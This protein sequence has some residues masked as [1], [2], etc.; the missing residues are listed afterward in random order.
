MLDSWMALCFI[1]FL[2]NQMFKPT[3]AQFFRVGINLPNRKYLSVP[4]GPSPS[5]AQTRNIRSFSEVYPEASCCLQ[6]FS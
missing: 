4:F 2:M 6:K 3:D 5:S 1:T